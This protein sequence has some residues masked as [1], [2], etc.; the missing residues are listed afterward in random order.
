MI[1]KSF[2]LL[3]ILVSL[4]VLSGGQ[5]TLTNLESK[6]GWKSC[7]QCAGTA[8]AGSFATHWYKQNVTS[9]VLEGASMQFFLGGTDNYSNAYWWKPVA[10]GSTA[11]NFVYD[12]YYYI[13]DSKAPQALEFEVNQGLNSK[14]Y[15]FGTQCG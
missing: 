4:G 15:I 8:G 2:A 11:T 5:T 1:R 12:F 6:T 3:C 14:K 9:P 10:Y 13:K 7:S